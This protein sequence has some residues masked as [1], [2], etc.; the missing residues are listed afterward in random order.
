VELG[1][2]FPISEIATLRGYLESIKRSTL[3]RDTGRR[4]PGFIDACLFCLAAA[5]KDPLRHSDRQE[6]D[7]TNH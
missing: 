2:E 6:L 7:H 3:R 1:T 4:Y 5:L